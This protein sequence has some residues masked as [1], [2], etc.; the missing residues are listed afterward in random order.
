MFAGFALLGTAP[1]VRQQFRLK[2]R[3]TLMLAVLVGLVGGL[4]AF[5]FLVCIWTVVLLLQ[6]LEELRCIEQLLRPA[7]FQRLGIDGPNHP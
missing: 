7:F 1:S 3:M 6:I 5:S 4:A 2:S